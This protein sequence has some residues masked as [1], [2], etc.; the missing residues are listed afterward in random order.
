MAIKYINNDKELGI[1]YDWRA[2]RKVYEGLKVPPEYD[3]INWQALP[4][5]KYIMELS[6]RSLGKTTCWLLVGCCMNKLYKTTI[7]YVR[8]TENMLAPSFAE[9]LVEVLRSYDNGAYVKKLTDG[10]YNSITYHWRQFFYCNIDESGKVVER[11][12]EPLIQCLSIDKHADYKSSYN[13]FLSRGDFVLFDEFIGTYYRPLE[14][15][16]FFDLLKTLFRNRISGVVVMLANTINLNSQYFEEFEISRAVKQLHKGD[17]KEIVTERGTRI[18]IEIIEQVMTETKRSL[19]NELFF[20]FSNPRLGAITGGEVW[21][22]E[23]V[24]HIP[25]RDEQENREVLVYNLFIESGLELLKVELVRDSKLGAHL[26]VHRASKTYDDSI[27]LTLGEL[28]DSRYVYG[29]GVG[30]LNKILAKYLYERK[31]L[32]SSNEVGSI[33]KDYLHRYKM[34]KGAV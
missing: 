1:E 21:A 20:G 24:P 13:T 18:Y 19:M 28:Q 23:A 11:S 2:I 32:Y 22:F 27:I 15:I 6:E 31:V 30:R 7:Q 8:Q 3:L 12:E 25:P 10:K 5:D 17:K 14:A 33:F 34:E 4:R 26:E 9:K 29:F 16:N